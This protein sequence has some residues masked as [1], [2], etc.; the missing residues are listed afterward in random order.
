[1]PGQHKT[2]W[3]VN[4]LRNLQ[5][6]NL[7]LRFWYTWI[8]K[9]GHIVNIPPNYG[10]VSDGSLNYVRI[11]T[12]N[13]QNV[14]GGMSGNGYQYWKLDARINGCLTGYDYVQARITGIYLM[15]VDKPT[16]TNIA[17]EL[18][19]DPNAVGSLYSFGIANN[20]LIQDGKVGIG[21]MGSG[22]LDVNGEITSKKVRV[23]QAG[24]GWPDYVFH[25]DY[26]LSP[27]SELAAYIKANKH[28]PDVPSAQEVER[29]GVDVGEMN[30]ILLQKIEELTLHLLEQQKRI[31]QL[32]A[33]QQE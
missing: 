6:S 16:S 33:K 4:M 13:Q 23:T 25:D 30:K 5:C 24:A 22:S 28:L 2:E 14:A 12:T 20:V 26:H 1:M 19:A 3:V 17:V 10:N 15:A 7:Q 9:P 32:E 8:N 31:E 11:P 27:L 18:N 21:L 29:S